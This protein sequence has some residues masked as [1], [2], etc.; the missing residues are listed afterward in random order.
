MKRNLLKAILGIVGVSLLLSPAVSYAQDVTLRVEGGV[1]I[2][3]TDPQSDRFDVGGAGDVKLDIGITPFFDLGPSVS[4][5]ALPS[6]V[7]GVST[8]TALGLGGFARLK[9][10]HDHENN[11]G[12]GFTAVSPWV[13]ADLQY[14]RTGP[15]DRAGVA[16]A[17]GAAVP[18]SDVRNVWVGPF[19]RYEN[20][21][22]AEKSGFDTSDAK[23][24]ILGVSI[25]LGPRHD[26]KSP[27]PPVKECADRDHDGTCDPVDRCPDVPGPKDN[28]GCPLPVPTPPAV[29]PEKI[30]LQ[31]KVQFDWDSS[32][33]RS[34]EQPG[35]DKAVKVLLAH[36]GYDVKIEGHAS[37][38]GPVEY[39]NRLAQKRADAVAAYL[40]SKGVPAGN[41]T[42]TGF[43]IK[44][45]VAT[46]ATEAGRSSNRRVEFVVNFVIVKKDSK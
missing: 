45:P 2:P 46:N 6:D 5:L 43:G 30:E 10:P 41:V 36:E 23:A 21:F 9:R 18:T 1:A 7:S 13:D 3:V 14:V 38:E 39:N 22:Q 33:I 31:G 12:K 4:I 44:V 17:I 25:E 24:L 32:K 40:V 42:A 27:P 29:T 37:S 16:L 26:K 8:G 34:V 19:A 20:V 28:F 15:L 35:L 11:T